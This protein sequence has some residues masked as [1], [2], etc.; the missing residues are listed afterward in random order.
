MT[1][2]DALDRLAQA[3][4]IETSYRDAW[5][6]TR[7]VP[8]EAVCGIL[9]VLGIAAA[10]DAETAASL[11]A[12]DDRRFARPL[13]PVAVVRE[14]DLPARVAVCL[15]PS[16]PDATIAWELETEDGTT[17]GGT[18]RIADLALAERHADGRER[19]V[20]VL[21]VTPPTGY[22]ALRVGDSETK[23]IVAPDRCYL[24]PALQ[25]DGRCWG[26]SLQLY[27]LRTDRNWGMGDFGDL[28]QLIDA[29]GARGAGALALNPLHALYP[30]DPHRFS[31]YGPSSRLYLNT[32][33]IDVE[34]VP[35]YEAS[36][37]AQIRVASEEFQARLGALREAPLIDYEGVAACKHEIFELLY[38]RF[39]DH[40]DAA[41]R[42]AFAAFCD[43]RGPTLR[44]LAAFEAL[45]ERFGSEE[46]SNADWR[47]WPEAFR[48]PDSPEVAAFCAENAERVGYFEYLQFVADAQL[49]EAAEG[50]AR[51]GMA[52]GICRDLALGVDIAGAE[53][54]THQAALA[55]SIALGAPPDALNLKGQDWGLPPYEPGRLAARA[56][57]PYVAVLRAN[58]RQAGA[59]RIDHV[60]GLARQYWIPRGL[61]A[62]DGGYVRFPMDDLLGIIALESCRNECLVIGE[63]LGTVPGGLRE[64]LRDEGIFSYRLLCFEKD[65]AGAFKT[66]D[67]YP[68]LA[69]VSSGTHDLPTLRGWWTGVDLQLRRSLDLFPDAATDAAET[70]LRAHDRDALLA[71]LAQAGLAV[72]AP[73]GED[74]WD[75]FAASVYRYLAATPSKLLLVQIEDL[76]AQ[77]DQVN[78]PGTVGEHP[79]WRRK[80]AATLDAVLELAACRPPHRR[81][82]AGPGTVTGAAPLS[83]VRLEQRLR[84]S[85]DAYRRTRPR[86]RAAVALRCGRCAAYSGERR[87]S[88]G[89]RDP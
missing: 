84:V 31:P 71:A 16:A 2:D 6:Q 46:R 43:T 85:G 64:R 60:L 75:D 29:A 63:D 19:R 76:V 35:E 72:A 30:G 74:D 54:W 23:L 5:G 50:C 56:Y 57:A 1:A 32:L 51:H 40:A 79:N 18:V 24:P 55:Q 81:R 3:A 38:A 41:R 89:W 25:G 33:Y 10:T 58:M 53:A 4:G 37:E 13:P 44:A 8:R 26:I 65:E 77:E 42:R 83:S 21:P 39:R 69:L 82:V 80:L 22:H 11:A 47:V 12:L 61:M 66:P 59:L 49:A 78:L 62:T 48:D 14:R 87:I 52:V 20:F 17:E 27:A 67:E 45:A 70:E 68:P 86:D 9:E 36:A 7:D 15:G 73:A 88:M 34:S 28:V